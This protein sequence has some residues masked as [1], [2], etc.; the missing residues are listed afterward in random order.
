VKKLLTSRGDPSLLSPDEIVHTLLV[1]A[2]VSGHLP[3]NENLLLDYL[4]LRQLSFDFM[5]ELEFV[6][7]SS[8]PPTNLRAALSLNDRLVAVQSGL[9][10]KRGRFSVLHEIGHFVLPEH[11]DRLFLDTDETLSWWTKLRLEREAN[12][13]AADLLFQGQRFTDEALDLPIAIQSVLDLAPRYAASYEAALRRLVERHV[14]PCAVIVYDKVAKT[15]ETDFEDDRFRIQ[16]TVTSEPFRKRFFSGV[17]T[18]E[19]SLPGAELYNPRRWGDIIKENLKV[20][21]WRFDTELFS[22]GYKI[23]Q[24]IVRPLDDK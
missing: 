12:K 16:Y 9:G 20:D 4:G 11:R 15:T 18:K 24:L 23:F 8:S 22:N 2:G 5:N 6:D 14:L 10:R 7:N 21:S 1:H 3:T 13:M 19:E 17:H